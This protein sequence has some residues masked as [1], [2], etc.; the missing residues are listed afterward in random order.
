MAFCGPETSLRNYHFEIAFKKGYYYC[1]CKITNTSFNI[2]NADSAK[3][4][5]EE[6]LAEEIEELKMRN[7]INNKSVL[8][9][10]EVR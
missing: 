6:I 7:E 10:M 8:E 1:G 3:P 9:Q 5:D 4:I 2:F